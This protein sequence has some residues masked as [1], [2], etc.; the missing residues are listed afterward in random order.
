M[1]CPFSHSSV[2][3]CY[4][5]AAKHNVQIIIRVDW[6]LFNYMSIIATKCERSASSFE[7]VYD[8]RGCFASD[9]ETCELPY[10]R[11]FEGCSEILP[12][13]N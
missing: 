13:S 11:K 12:A 4:Q 6:G 3:R 7:L 5:E 10:Q 2:F 1:Q 9:S 8:R